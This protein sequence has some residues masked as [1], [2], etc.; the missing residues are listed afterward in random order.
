MYLQSVI[1]FNFERLAISVGRDPVI[2]FSSEIESIP[3]R[4]FVEFA[5]ENN[6]NI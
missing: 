3:K 4:S 2:L 5:F 1:F 6:A